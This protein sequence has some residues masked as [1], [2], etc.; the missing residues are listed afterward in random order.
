MTRLASRLAVALGALALLAGSAFADAGEQCRDDAMLVLDSSGSMAGTDMSSLT[1][2]VTKV[3]EALAAVVP[4]VAPR[5]NLGLLVYGPG[6]DARCENIDLKLPPAPNS[7]ETI[8][9]EVNRVVPFGETPLTAAVRDAAEVLEFREKPSVVVLLTDGEETCGGDPCQLARQLKAEAR[10]LTI[11]VVSFKVAGAHTWL[12]PEKRS[13]CMAEET[14]GLALTAETRDELIQALQ[15]TL[16]CPLFSEAS[17]RG[18]A[19]R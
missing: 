16:G 8:L 17:R 14:G 2:H 3:R 4:E 9:G 15:K 10:Q 7:A 6:K 18:T 11:H 19:E 5:R 12:V 1:P 13:A